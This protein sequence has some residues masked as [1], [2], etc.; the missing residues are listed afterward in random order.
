MSLTTTTA[1]ILAGRLQTGQ[2]GLELASPHGTQR[3]A[4]HRQIIR[5]ESSHVFRNFMPS[6]D[7]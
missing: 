4:P 3:P 7:R 2:C 6:V 1:D 5:T